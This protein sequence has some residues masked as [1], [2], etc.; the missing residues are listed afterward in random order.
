MGVSRTVA[1]IPDAFAKD[2]SRFKAALGQLDFGV[3]G[4]LLLVR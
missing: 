4:M 1:S 2:R 3:L